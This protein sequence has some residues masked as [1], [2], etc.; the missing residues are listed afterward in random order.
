MSRIS[1]TRPGRLAH[2]FPIDL[3][4]PR[5]IEQT[6]TPEFIKVV[7]EIKQTIL[8]GTYSVAPAE[9]LALEM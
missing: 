7:L 3:P 2:V 6:F 8:S 9:R 1:T 4:R 5:T